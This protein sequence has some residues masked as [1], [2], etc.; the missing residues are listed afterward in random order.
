METSVSS[1][2]AFGQIRSGEQENYRINLD[3]FHGPLDLLLYLIRKE[4]VDIY[5]IPI[6]KITRQYLKY[7]EMMTTLN[8]E[9]AGE[10][11]LMAATLIRIKTR[12]LLPRNEEDQ[13]DA[14]PREELIMALIEYKKYK[15]A[16]DILKDKALYE[17]QHY[18]PSHP[19][20]KIEG[21]IDLQPVT[22]IFDLLSAFRD[23]MNSNHDHTYHEVDSEK[24]T[25]EDRIQYIQLYLA[26]KEFATFQELFSDIPLK[27]VAVVTFLAMLELAFAQ[28][29]VIHQSKPFSELRIYRGEKFYLEKQDIDTKTVVSVK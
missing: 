27:V 19:V 12:L 2:S 7:I 23:I 24:V 25:V 1:Q 18:I 11:I 15:E 13:D 3:V 20:E 5:D 8:L 28:N 21:K 16:G 17:E 22:T 4:E 29:I 6:A 9:V 26:N 14:D 10:F